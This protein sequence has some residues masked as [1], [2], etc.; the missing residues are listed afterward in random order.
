MDAGSEAVWTGRGPTP[1][2]ALWCS[3]GGDPAEGP[4]P[5]GRRC[6]RPDTPLARV[7]VDALPWRRAGG[8]S[9]G[10][11]GRDARRDG[12]HPG[13]AGARGGVRLL[14]RAAWVHGLPP[15][16]TCQSGGHNL[17]APPQRG[18]LAPRTGPPAQGGG[19]PRARGLFLGSVARH[20]AP[21]GGGPRRLN[22]RGCPSPPPPPPPA[23]AGVGRPGRGGTRG[24]HVR[25]ACAGSP[26]LLAAAV[27][28]DRPATAEG[29]GRIDPGPRPLEAPGPRSRAPHGRDGGPGH[30]AS[31]R[32]ARGWGGGTGPGAP[33]SGAAGVGGRRAA[34]APLPAE[35]RP[36]CR[37]G[38][39]RP[40][41]GPGECGGHQGA[42]PG[43]VPTESPPGPGRAAELA[44]EGLG[45]G[46]SAGG[47]GQRC[48]GARRGGPGPAAREP[49]RHRRW[50]PGPRAVPA[51]HV[52]AASAS[53]PR[54]ARAKRAQPRRGRP[55]NGRDTQG[56]PGPWQA[57]PAAAVEVAHRGGHGGTKVFRQ[58]AGCATT[59]SASPGHRGSR[60]AHRDGG[61]GE[62]TRG[63]DVGPAAHGSWP[64]GRV[65]PYGATPSP[66]W[67]SCQATTQWSKPSRTKNLIIEYTGQRD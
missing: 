40:S 14:P 18:A 7:L 55:H 29:R 1:R 38:R 20:D 15:A 37:G 35:P 60:P 67:I 45:R 53:G 47:R 57:G 4:T 27:G 3:A 28:E 48:R 59:S 58:G 32:R 9:A 46:W 22:A 21:L 64:V 61:P 33:V 25:C 63:E 24:G 11:G 52:S 17:P 26:A 56:P 5:R 2:G 12:A 13:G 6:H 34:L 16:D 41:H 51:H 44:G 10:A 62:P 30:A 39:R 42:G 54:R 66:S 43:C 8:V 36:A 31:P 49:T 65:Q 19:E 50:V 23:A